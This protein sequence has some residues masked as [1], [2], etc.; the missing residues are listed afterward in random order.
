MTRGELVN[1]VAAKLGMREAAE[2][3]LIQ[4]WANAA[5]VDVLLRTHAFLQMGDMDLVADVSEYRLDPKVLAIDDG[6]TSTPAGIGPYQVVTLAEMIAYQSINPVGS[7]MRKM[8]AIQSDFLIVAPVPST[9]ETIRFY[10]V[11]RPDPMTADANDPSDSTYGGLAT[12]YHR[13]IEYYMLW[14]GSEYDDKVT[15][16]AVKEYRAAYENEC[17]DIRKRTRRKAGRGLRGGRA[18]YPAMFRTGRNDVY[19]SGD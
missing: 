4:T 7:G 2:T 12:E 5:V 13:A 1:M 16:V 19:S 15:A 10:Y 18:G 11:P 8:I 14:Q 17:R 9:S 6:R 3:T